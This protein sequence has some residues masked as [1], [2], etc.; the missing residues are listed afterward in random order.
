M[1]LDLASPEVD[2][3]CDLLDRRLSALNQRF[4]DEV[5][6]AAHLTDDA[7]LD[8]GYYV[9]HR[10]ETIKR[11][12]MTARTDALALTALIRDDYD[13][14]RVWARYACEEL[15]HDVMFYDDLAR[16][17]LSREGI[18]DVAPLDATVLLVGYLE[19]EIGSSG[20]LPAVA[21]SVFVEWNSERFS[22]RA[23]EK[24]REAFGDDFVRGSSDHLLVDERENH[25]REMIALAERLC[26]GSDG[27]ER[28]FEL[29]DEIARL[30]RAYFI[31]LS[32]FRG[33]EFARA[34]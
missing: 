5:P 33:K 12:R 22:R 25:S 29:I 10:I 6:G 18:D 9:R 34:A 28:L 14:A 15:D 27:T 3:L 21:Y 11:I 17:G 32:A 31:E 20:S 19:R 16:H 24:A 26:R 2:T 1:T 30:F 7:E 8:H 4:L 13:A 23:V